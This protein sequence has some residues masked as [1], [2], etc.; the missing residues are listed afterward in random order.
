MAT[1]YE[2]KAMSDHKFRYFVEDQP[3][4][5]RKYYLTLREMG[6]QTFDGPV[7]QRDI[8]P[9]PSQINEERKAQRIRDDYARSQE[10]RKNRYRT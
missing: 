3:P 6:T 7:N 4:C 2:V 9:P 1:F 8:L 5:D 10:E